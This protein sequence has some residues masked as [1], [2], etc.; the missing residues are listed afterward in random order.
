MLADVQLE[1]GAGGR[2]GATGKQHHERDA[3]TP[4][5]T[6]NGSN[7]KRR[8]ILLTM[9]AIF[10]T[11]G[12]ALGCC[13]IIFV[14]SQREKTDDAYVVGN[15][16]RRLAPNSPAPWSRCSRAIPRRWNPA[17]RC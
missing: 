12:I 10:I 5:P 2:P 6:G 4:H 14:L 8:R 3:T 7:G 1:A 11:L 17:R 16:M 15:Q 13:W 9:A